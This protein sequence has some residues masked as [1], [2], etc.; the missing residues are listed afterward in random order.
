ME[1]QARNPVRSQGYSAKVDAD[2]A[3]NSI[4]QI[5]TADGANAK[6]V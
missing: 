1:A 2:V 5:A 6:M 4:L 3:A